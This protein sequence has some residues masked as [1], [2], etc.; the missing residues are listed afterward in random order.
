MANGGPDISVRLSAQGVQDVIN[1]MRRIRQ[2]GK[3]TGSA[4]SQIGDSLK[5]LI[6]A[7]SIGAAVAGFTK[8]VLAVRETEENIGKLSEKTG[9]SVETLS[10]LNLVAHDNEVSLESLT[11]GLVKLTKAQVAAVDGSSKQSSVFQSLGISIKDLKTLDPA[12]LFVKV[13]ASLDKLPAGARKT[14]DSLVLFGKSGADLIPMLDAL[15]KDGFDQAYDKAKRLGVLLSKDMVDSAGSAQAS[16]HE[17]EDIAAGAA[18]QFNK[19]FMGEA[20]HAV[21]QFAE[22]VSG[23]GGK[24]FEVLGQVAGRALIG[25]VNL[26]RAAAAIIAGVFASALQEVS[27]DID[28]I[29]KAW[30]GFQKG[31]I[32]GAWK[33]FMSSQRDNRQIQGA[34]WG[35]T[36]SDLKKYWNDTINPQFTAPVYRKRPDKD[37]NNLPDKDAASKAAKAY[38]DLLQARAENELAIQRALAQNEAA[39]DKRKYDAGLMTLDEYY[40]AREK[41]IN[42][43]TVAEAAILEKKY[44]AAQGL[45]QDTPE[46]QAKREQALEQISSQ[47]A[48]LYIKN[49]G[50]LQAAEDERAKARHDTNLKNLQEQQQLAQM[51]GDRSKAQQI[52][53]D[54]ELQQYAELLQ[55]QGMSAD[56]IAKA[57]KSYKDQAQAKIDFGIAAQSGSVGLSGLNTDISVVQAQ[58]GAGVISQAQ[59]TSQIIDLERKRLNQLQAIGQEMARQAELA[60]DPQMEEQAKQFNAQ[61]QQISLSLKNV[62]SVGVEFSNQLMNSLG[63]FSDSLANAL[64]GTKTWS[65]T[66]SDIAKD[67]ESMIARMISRLLV[68][69]AIEAVLGWV[70]PE[71]SFKKSLSAKGPFG[72]KSGGYT[73]DGDPNGVAGV[74]HKGEFVFDAPTT[75]ANRSLFETIAAG[76]SLP[77]FATPATYAAM[78]SAQAGASGG[79]VD[80]SSLAPIINITTPPGT[81]VQQTQRTG[82]NGQSVTD[83]IVSA[84][85][86]DIGRRGPIAKTLETTYGTT[87]QGTRRSS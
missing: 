85:V 7:I 45:P 80:A 12:A 18:T 14:A 50:D 73:G 10:V 72:F 55:K 29:G 31:G 36:G 38:S 24:G 15:G 6:P 21:E 22:S 56:A 67:F 86:G 63:G 35:Q 69:W 68:F 28:S 78:A 60:K 47:A 71:S 8:L 53:L 59:A 11:S 82:S 1:A 39:I 34:I 37:L 40:D 44:N 19:G 48:Q 23:T 77:P 74:V 62:T 65:D 84:V 3:D 57:T 52:A 76:R 33:S 5:E 13:S 51:E 32:S 58:S 16:I 20:T 49:Q 27:G 66:F 79:G 42:D 70:A 41:R 25:I 87:R 4:L 81:Q 75:S 83:I 26:F 2:E 46:Q 17:L 54:I 43:A 9:A 61:L 30:E 64:D